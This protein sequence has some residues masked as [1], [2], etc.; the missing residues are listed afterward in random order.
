MY[1]NVER[2]RLGVTRRGPLDP[3]LGRFAQAYHLGV[4]SQS[5][6]ESVTSWCEYWPEKFPL[7]HPSPRN[8]PWFKKNVWFEE[9]VLP[10]LRKRVKALV[11]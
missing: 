2:S 7:P 3:L 11:L 9:D 4:P 5:V 8:P 6:T 10:M 1:P